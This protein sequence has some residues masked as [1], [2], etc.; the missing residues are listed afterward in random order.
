M[1]TKDRHALCIPDFY[2]WGLD[3]RY[4]MLQ[5][6]ELAAAQGI[7]EGYDFTGNKTQTTKQI[8]NAVPVNLGKSLVG[9]SFF[10][11]Y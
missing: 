4:R 7:P 10:S 8:R 6:R 5:P 9:Q 11:K 3:L 2:P 1:T